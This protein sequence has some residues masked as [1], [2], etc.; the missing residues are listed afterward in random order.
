MEVPTVQGLSRDFTPVMHE[1]VAYDSAP[2]NLARLNSLN[3]LRVTERPHDSVCV[4]RQF[5]AAL[6][7]K[8]VTKCSKNWYQ[9]A[10]G[11]D[12]GQ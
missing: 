11:G 1:G 4:T 5:Q 3:Q 6:A 10:Y 12:V 2:V 9:C 8:G 7:K